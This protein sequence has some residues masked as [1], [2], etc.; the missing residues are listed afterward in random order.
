MYY[1]DKDTVSSKSD[2]EVRLKAER[3]NSEAAKPE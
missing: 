3:S 2:D 1:F